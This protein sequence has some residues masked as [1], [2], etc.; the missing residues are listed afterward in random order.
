[1]SNDS[2]ANSLVLC[3]PPLIPREADSKH[4]T[5]RGIQACSIK[6]S[7]VNLADGGEMESKGVEKRPRGRLSAVQE[8][9][10]RMLIPL[11]FVKEKN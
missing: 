3:M 11:V 9:A 4:F 7:P 10:A 8:E 1:L 6:V 5:C 2:L